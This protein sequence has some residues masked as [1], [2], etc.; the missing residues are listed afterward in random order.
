[1]NRKLGIGI[2]AVALAGLAVI[3]VAALVTL[4]FVIDPNRTVKTVQAQEPQITEPQK[5]LIPRWFLTSLTVQGQPVELIGPQAQSIQFTPDG[6]VNGQ[7]GCNSFGGEYQARQDGKLTIGQLISTQMACADG[8]AQETAYL[9]ALGQVQH[10][11]FN[12][13]MKLVLTSE[14]GKTT[15][16]FTRPPK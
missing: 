3:I 14:D 2:I 11:Q 6:K 7:G 1:M 15:L 5:L 4:I 16:V 12:E 10:F 9:Q 13:Q 8:M